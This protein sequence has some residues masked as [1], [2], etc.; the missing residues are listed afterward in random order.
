MRTFAVTNSTKYSYPGED[1]ATKALDHGR[2]PDGTVPHD[3]HLITN[4]KKR[5]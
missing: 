2:F 5:Y 3:D 4:G 1:A